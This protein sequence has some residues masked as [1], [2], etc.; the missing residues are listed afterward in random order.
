MQFYTEEELTEWF[1][2]LP[3]EIKEQDGPKPI[4]TYMDV[5]N[6]M[7]YENSLQYE[8]EMAKLRHITSDTGF[9]VLA[10]LGLWNGKRVGYK[11]LQA[12]TL[13]EVIQWLVGR[14][15]GYVHIYVEK[16]GRSSDV[17]VQDRHHD[18][19]NYYRIRVPNAKWTYTTENRVD[20]TVLSG[21]N[22]NEVKIKTINHY[23]KSVAPAVCSV[24]G[25]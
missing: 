19:D 4:R 12:R 16:N 18:G 3:D 23:T 15:D 22:T 10:E 11:Y 17:I 25:W 2:Y 21:K 20:E 9:V 1:S 13:I 8:D 5:W 7:A 14:A 24:Y 6:N